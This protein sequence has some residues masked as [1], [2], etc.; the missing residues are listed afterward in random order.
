[1]VSALTERDVA[2]ACCHGTFGIADWN[3]H[4]SVSERSELCPTA[5]VCIFA[6]R[7]P[8]LWHWMFMALCGLENGL[9]S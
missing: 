1:M 5:I 6:V 3:R 9:Y 2:N 7:T 4:A 8:S